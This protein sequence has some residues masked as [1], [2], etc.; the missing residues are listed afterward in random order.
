MKNKMKKKVIRPK[1]PMTAYYHG[2][3]CPHCKKE[4]HV[5]IPGYKYRQ[6]VGETDFCPYC[7]G[8]LDWSE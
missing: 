4:F 5:S 8:A 6:A 2:E 7:G 1:D 3:S